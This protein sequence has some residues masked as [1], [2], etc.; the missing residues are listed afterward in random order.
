[1]DGLDLG[2]S[3]S[4]YG[5]LAFQAAWL[6]DFWVFFSLIALLF[7]VSLSLILELSERIQTMD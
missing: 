2:C 3:G 1:M 4:L 7:L 6:F 5:S